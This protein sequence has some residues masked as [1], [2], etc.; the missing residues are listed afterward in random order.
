[1]IAALLDRAASHG[2][3]HIITTITPGNRASWALFEG[4]ARRL[5]AGLERTVLF[6][7][8]V[9]FGGAH[10][11]E[12]QVCIGPLSAVPNDHANWKS[13]R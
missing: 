1:M 13:R 7:R 11:T 2:V 4:L 5:N 8:N 9:H 10:A 12:W 6:D 3:R